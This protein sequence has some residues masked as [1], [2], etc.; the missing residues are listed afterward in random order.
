MGN[1]LNFGREEK[2]KSKKTQDT[3][4]GSGIKEKKW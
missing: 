4:T 3:D 1:L 2:E